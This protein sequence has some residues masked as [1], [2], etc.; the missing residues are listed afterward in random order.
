MAEETVKFNV[1]YEVTGIDGSVRNTQ[2][3]LYAMNAVRLSV[4]DIQEVMAGPTLQ[5]VMWTAIQLTR[6]WTSLYRLINAVNKEQ[7]VGLAMGVGRAATGGAGISALGQTT[8]AFG[9]GGQLGV[10]ARGTLWGAITAFAAANPLVVGAAAAALV[11]GSAVAWDASQRQMHKD[12]L[13]RQREAAKSQ[14]I[15]Y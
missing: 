4:R 1:E 6:V 7:K 12:W 11:V 15:E 14:G 9:A 3:L 5:N 2:R 13:Q 10:A 8:L